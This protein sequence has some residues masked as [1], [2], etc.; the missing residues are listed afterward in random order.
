MT[1]YPFPMPRLACR[2]GTSS[3]RSNTQAALHCRAATISGENRVQ[4]KI[5]RK[6]RKAEIF[7]SAFPGF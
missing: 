4:P 2:K 1:H 5:E 7:D 3:R 6:K